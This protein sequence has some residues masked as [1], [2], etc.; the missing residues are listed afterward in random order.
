MS[1]PGV[2]GPGASEPR[3]EDPEEFAEEAGVDPTPQEVDHYRELAEEVP[4]WSE[5]AE[6][7]PGA[8]DVR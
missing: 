1:E 2:E 6:D 7:D 3:A 4:P 5:P 8:T